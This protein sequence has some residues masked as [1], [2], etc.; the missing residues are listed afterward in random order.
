MRRAPHERRARFGSLTHENGRV[1]AIGDSMRY[2]T[3]DGACRYAPSGA[4]EILRS[5]GGRWWETLFGRMVHANVFEGNDLATV[6]GHE[7][8]E[9]HE[10]HGGH[11]N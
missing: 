2:R 7:E 3:C 8:H 6:W 4:N 5:V 1:Y 11:R 9:E 10:E